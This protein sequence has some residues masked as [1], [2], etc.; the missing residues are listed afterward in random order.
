MQ[1]MLV[2]GGKLVYHLAKRLIAKGY[3]V[4]VI[5]KDEIY[6]KELARELN[7]TIV[8][9]EASD[10]DILEDAGAF[11]TDVLVALTQ[12]DHD[13]LFICKMAK[14]Y[15]GIERTTSIVNNPDNESLFKK[16]G[17]NGIFNLTELLSSLIEQNVVSEDIRN[18]VTLEEGK[19][20]VS[21]IIIPEDA[22][23]AGKKVRVINLPLSIVLGGIIRE[24]N[25][26]IPRGETVIKPGDK[27][28][29]ISLPEDQ[30]LAIRILG[31]EN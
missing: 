29:V 14:E 7:A 19:L 17:I 1:I 27:V 24:G 13:N 15:F 25:V 8:C 4:V 2:G 21:Q 28:L 16:M 18:L 10:K 30:A 6:T 26:I 5:N 23:A 9:G 22:P 11:R 20:S 12:K 3:F 31:G